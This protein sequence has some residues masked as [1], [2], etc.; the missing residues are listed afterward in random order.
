MIFDECMLYLVDY[1]VVKCFMELLLCWVKCLKIVYGDSLLVL[2]GIVQGG[3]YED[4][5]LCLL[6]GLQEIGFDGLVIGGLLVG[7][8]KEE[9]ICVFDFLLLQMLVDKLCYLM[10]VGKLEDLVEG[11]CCGVDMF[12]C[13]MLMCNVCNGYLFVDSGVIKICNLVY[14]YDDFMFDLICDCYICKY[15]FCVYLYY[16]DKCGEMFGSMFNIIYNL[17]YY[18]W[19]MVGLCEVI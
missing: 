6:D 12:D 13:V 19:V 14:K 5:C 18:Q 17:W 10:G 3:M 1:D 4:L 9:M 16:L 7:E 2:F 8:L 11:V 15:F